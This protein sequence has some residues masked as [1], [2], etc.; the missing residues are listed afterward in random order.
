[1]T[2]ALLAACAGNSADDSVRWTVQQAESIASV[3]GT[4]VRPRRCH[5]RGPAERDDG[6]LTYER[7]ACVA[8]ARR[9]GET[10]DTVAVL[11]DLLPR[12]AYPDHELANVRFVGG[13]GIP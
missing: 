9:P 2:F 6:A 13:P 1:V 7:F 5:G 10:V 12:G 3:R 11:Y 8:G 4:P